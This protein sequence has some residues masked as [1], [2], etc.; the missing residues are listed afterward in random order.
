MVRV[1]DASL[2]LLHPLTPFVTEELWGRLKAA[3]QAH[4]EHLSPREGWADALIM[5]K[6][7]APRKAEGWEADKIAQFDLLQEVVRAIRNL[8]A[9]KKVKPS[10]RIPAT[11]AA[12][13]MA[14]LLNG[15]KSSLAGLARLDESR[16]T[17]TETLG[18]KPDGTV[19]L[20]AGP[21][22]IFLPL[23]DMV[24]VEE[25]RARLQKD[26]KNAESQIARIKKMLAGPFAQK[27]PPHVVDGEREKLANFQETAEKIRAQLAQL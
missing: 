10:M 19:A 12:G 23:A 27:A 20:V 3:A 8:R 7:P 2:R 16:L 15:M 1:L 13:E 21:V 25:E 26:L 11:F 22:E 6:Y 14:D 24:D 9:E 18:D 5:A 4:S 17:I